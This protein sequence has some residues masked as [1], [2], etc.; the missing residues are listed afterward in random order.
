[1][2]SRP[3]NTALP[4]A[5]KSGG[6]E[7]AA[8]HDA[9]ALDGRSENDHWPRL[10]PTISAQMRHHLSIIH[11]AQ[12][13]VKRYGQSSRPGV[14]GRQGQFGARGWGIGRSGPERRTQQPVSLEA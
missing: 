12:F 2:E 13:Q 1:M 3:W 14:S 8:P 9:R 11:L 5:K 6:A 7:S 10:E 4:P